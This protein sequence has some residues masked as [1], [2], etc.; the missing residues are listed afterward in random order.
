[1][2]FFEV[3][4]PVDSQDAPGLKNAIFET[5]HKH[6]LESVLS[7]IIFLSSD[8]ASVNSGNQAITTIFSL[9]QFYLVF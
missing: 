4:P 9:D 3:V 6:S 8:G 7:K 2:K 5:F 1:M